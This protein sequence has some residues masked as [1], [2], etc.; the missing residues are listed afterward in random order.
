L[1]AAESPCCAPRAPVQVDFGC[2]QQLKAQSEHLFDAVDTATPSF[3]PPPQP[4]VSTLDRNLVQKSST[5]A[6]ISVSAPR[7]A[8]IS[9]FSDISAAGCSAPSHS[10]FRIGRPHFGKQFRVGICQVSNE[11]ENWHSSASSKRDEP[12]PVV[13]IGKLLFGNAEFLD[14]PINEKSTCK[15]GIFSFEN[16]AFATQKFYRSYAACEENEPPHRKSESYAERKVA[17][18]LKLKLYICWLKTPF[19]RRG[20]LS[21]NLCVHLMADTYSAPKQQSA[22]FQPP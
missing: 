14:S 17:Y 21:V 12:F 5:L 13:K 15:I 11:Q 8:K 6:D 4:Q 22:V 3:S 1:S 18:E 2:A 7:T 9:S 16:S 19:C 20:S 10:T